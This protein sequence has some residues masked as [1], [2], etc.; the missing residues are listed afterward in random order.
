MNR[1][2]I[3]VGY[4]RNLFLRN[5]FGELLHPGDYTV[6]GVIAHHRFLTLL[7]KRLS[8]ELVARVFQQCYLVVFA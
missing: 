5:K 7:A 4:R 8:R 2:P 1:S 3:A 6:L